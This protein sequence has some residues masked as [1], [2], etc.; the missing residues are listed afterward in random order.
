MFSDT[1]FHFHGMVTDRGINGSEVL[2]HMAATNCFFGLDIGTRCDDLL[3]RQETIEKAISDISDK[4]L[5]EKA[6]NFIYYSAGIWPDVEA[7]KDRHAQ[8]KILKDFI[9]KGK[10]I[11]AIGEGGIDHHWNPSGVDGHCESDYNT[12]IY[13]GEHELFEM[14]LELAKEMD[15]PYIVHSRDGFQD[16]LDCIKNIG[17]NKG[18]IHCYSYGVQEAKTFLDLGWYISFSGSV[19]YTKKAKMDEMHELL[20]LVPKERILCETDAPYLAPVPFRGQ[21]NTPALVDNTYR[22]IAEQR[23]I[24]VEELCETVDENI[25]NLFKV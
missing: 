7:I 20:N 18:I 17:W 4:N 10:R 21:P 23:N 16:T 22:F 9:S 14:Q 13:Q 12:E 11:V 25:R 1:H 3:Y 8:M 24:S 15:L 6:K 2:S 19:T 5:A